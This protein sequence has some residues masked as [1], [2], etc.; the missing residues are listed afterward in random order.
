[1]VLPDAVRAVEQNAFDE[2][3]GLVAAV[4]PGA[5]AE[6]GEASAQPAWWGTV[7]QGAFKGCTRLAAVVAP[8]AVVADYAPNFEGCGELLRRGGLKPRTAA[9]LVAALKLRFWHQS[10]HALLPAPARAAVRALL[11]ALQRAASDGRLVLLPRLMLQ[12]VLGHL[13]PHQLGA[14]G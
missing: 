8:A 3:T 7:T 14:T 13:R 1:M 9:T 12:T 11:L 10:T 2:C 6:L 5:L 4:L